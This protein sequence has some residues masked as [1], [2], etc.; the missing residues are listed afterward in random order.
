MRRLKLEFVQTT[1]AAGLQITSRSRGFCSLT[2]FLLSGPSDLYLSD[3]DLFP[4]LKYVRSHH[5]LHWVTR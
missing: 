1:T 3:I 2:I 4:I 5:F